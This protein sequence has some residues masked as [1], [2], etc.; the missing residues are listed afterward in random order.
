[1][2]DVTQIPEPVSAVV[3]RW[4]TDPYSLGAYSY[5][6]VGFTDEDQEGVER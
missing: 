3:T 6:P 4:G 1:M 2:R 5:F